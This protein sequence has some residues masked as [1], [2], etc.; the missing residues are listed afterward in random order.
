MHVQ[1]RKELPFADTDPEHTWYSTADTTTP[2]S[3]PETATA[4][5]TAAA[6]GAVAGQPQGPIK[7][8][9]PPAKDPG[10]AAKDATAAANPAAAAM[11]ADGGAASK[12]RALPNAA[13]GSGLAEASPGDHVRRSRATE[14]GQ[15]F[16]TAVAAFAAER[17]GSHDTGLD[18]EAGNQPAEAAADEASESAS[19]SEPIEQQ[20]Y[21]DQDTS[22][23]EDEEDEEVEDEEGEDEE[24]EEEEADANAGQQTLDAFPLGG[25]QGEGVKLLTPIERSPARE[26][27]M[28]LISRLLCRGPRQAPLGRA[29]HL[30]GANLQGG[31]AEE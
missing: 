12:D 15:S 20:P 18:T 2:A 26:R 10:A 7:L 29:R 5:V 23:E 25:R 16:N 3:E 4:A 31:G 11:D 14:L 28:M 13:A 17:S 27:H 9:N 19:G 1:V 8:A 22:A 6:A 24:E 30:H 21:S